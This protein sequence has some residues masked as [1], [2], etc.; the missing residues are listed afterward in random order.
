VAA[1]GAASAFSAQ[2]GAEMLPRRKIDVYGHRGASASRPEHTL[3]SYALAI[4]D[5]ADYVEPDL[6]ITNDG[7]LIVRHENDLT[8]TTDVK[9]HTEFASR[10][11]TRT[12]DGAAVTG[13]FCE[14]FTLAEIKTLRATERLPKVRPQNTA[15]DGVFEIVTFAE[16]LDFV[17]VEAAAR[18]R[19]IGIAPEIKH[20]TYFAARGLTM[21]DRFIAMLAAHSY[22]RRAPIAIQ[23]FE[24]ANLKYLRTKF[25]RTSNLSLVQLLDA[26]DKHLPDAAASGV[27]SYATML[28]TAGIAAIASYADVLAPNTRAI[29]PLDADGRLAK[30]TPLV[31]AAHAASL[32]VVPWTF[33]P[34]NQFLAVDFR[35]GD[36][37]GARNVDGSV[38]EI[39]RYLEAG[40]DGFF[41]DDPAIGRRAV[42]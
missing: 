35:N 37:D 21:E 36:G 20:S 39:G 34:E 27:T 28:T 42:G 38:A 6:V 12:I 33:R 32:R 3:A 30:P 26:P 8:E 2:A 29:I 1:L 24:I 40:I 14:D 16:F 13:W 9:A 31:A 18:G 11:K 4:A 19:V 23:S 41:T 5:G 15:Y 17:A 7:V 22:T 10:R 25:G